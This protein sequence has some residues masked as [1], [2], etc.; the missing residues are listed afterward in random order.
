MRTVDAG[1]VG[2]GA[3][4]EPRASAVRVVCHAV[5]NEVRLPRLCAD[6]PAAQQ[7]P[8]VRFFFFFASGAIC[9]ASRTGQGADIML[10]RGSVP[11]LRVPECGMEC[12]VI[13]TS[14]SSVHNT[15][16]VYTCTTTLLQH[17][18]ERL[19]VPMRHWVAWGKSVPFLSGCALSSRKCSRTATGTIGEIRGHPGPSLR[20]HHSRHPDV[21]LAE[22]LG[23]KAYGPTIPFS[24]HCIS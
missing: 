1:A 14:P 15:A 23:M 13:V 5:V 3:V 9:G 6:P 20:K 2:V 16:S 4:A 17:K 11:S 7:H 24:S 8:L 19:C 21:R 12:I 22:S 10:R 18:R